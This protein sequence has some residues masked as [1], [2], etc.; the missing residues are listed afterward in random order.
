MYLATESAKV[1]GMLADFCL[2]DLLT[3][4]G[5]V[6]GA[7]LANNPDLF[8]ALRLQQVIESLHCD[9]SLSSTRVRAKTGNE[10]AAGST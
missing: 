7:I 4:T 8:S 2:L 6:P 1:L 3:Q 5:T 9:V 10:A